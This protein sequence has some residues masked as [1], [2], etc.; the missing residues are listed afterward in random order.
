MRTLALVVGSW[1][2]LS[3]QSVVTTMGCGST[4]PGH[5]TLNG[6]VQ[7]G[8]FV[9]GSSITVSPLDA[10]GGPTGQTF[11]TQTTNDKG[12][13]VVNF[14]ASG[15]VA[16]QG[17]GFYYNEV[18][19]ALSG[20]PLTLRA[21][22]VIEQAGPQ[23]AFVNLITH[24]TF[25]RVK[26]LVSNG[27]TFVGAVAQAEGE[28]SGELA[29]TLPGFDPGAH[30][31]EMNLLGGDTAA[32]AYLLAAS[33]VLVQAAGSDAGLQELSNTIATDLEEDGVLGV[34]NKAKIA[35]G[36]LA[37]D[38]KAV[39][40]NLAKRLD[41]LGSSTTVPDIDKVLDQ[42]GDGLPNDKDNCRR[43]G[44]S[45]QKD[46]DGDGSGDV[47][48]V[49]PY[50]V[51]GPGEIAKCTT[52]QMQGD[53]GACYVGCGTCEFGNGMSC[54]NDQT[55]C[56]CKTDEKECSGTCL[57]DGLAPGE[58]RGQHGYCAA[59]CN[60][61]MPGC[62]EG[63]T[64]FSTIGSGVYQ[65]RLKTVATYV[66]EGNICGDGMKG[67][68]HDEMGCAPGLQC[69]PGLGGD[70]P[71]FCRAFCDVNAVSPCTEGTCSSLADTFPLSF[72]GTPKNVGVCLP[73]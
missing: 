46:S 22:Y 13:F 60:P 58:P 26:R 35:E 65:C 14:A 16:I 38:S 61:L 63:Q 20:A 49:C 73:K 7:K 3:F 36:A 27:L 6:A 39:M 18:S 12:E 23:A 37:L 62:A 59:T 32:N 41:E 44:N 52:P 42:D 66:L 11:L 1:V 47:C 34:T 8:P 43:A 48:D 57:N 71:F 4:E 53:Y 15:Q 21:L 10:N 64:C 55:G 40:A 5:V 30:G 56:S 31:I 28:L 25:L 67:S 24:L 45:D 2:A 17:E 51:C 54:N 19:G 70:Y 72:T 50:T 69:V 68:T 33:A 29:I 9:V